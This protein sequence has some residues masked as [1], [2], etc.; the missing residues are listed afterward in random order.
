MTENDIT[1]VYLQ[2]LDSR[3]LDPISRGINKSR[4][5][6]YSD[7]DNKNTEVFRRIYGSSV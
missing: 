7:R 2:D 1:K 4:N 6:R 5:I 3:S